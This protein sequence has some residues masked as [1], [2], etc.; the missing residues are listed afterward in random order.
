MKK[1][2]AFTFVGLIASVALTGCGSSSDDGGD[3][4]KAPRVEEV[5]R[6][7]GWESPETAIGKKHAAAKEK[8]K[9]TTDGDADGGK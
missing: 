9:E 3:P 6:P 5:K 7:E 2:I 4:S 1:L 8:M